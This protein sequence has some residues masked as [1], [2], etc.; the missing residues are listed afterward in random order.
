MSRRAARYP[1]RPR[2]RFIKKLYE[3]HLGKPV[4]TETVPGQPYRYCPTCHRNRS[5]DSFNK[6][7]PRTLCNNCR[8]A[9]FR[10]CKICLSTFWGS[11]NVHVCSDE[12]WEK[13]APGLSVARINKLRKSTWETRPRP[14]KLEGK[15]HSF[16]WYVKLI[17]EYYFIVEIAEL[18]EMFDTDLTALPDTAE[19]LREKAAFKKFTGPRIAAFFDAID[20]GNFVGPAARSVGVSEKTIAAWVQRGVEERKGNYWNFAKTLRMKIASVEVGLVG[21]VY[22]RAMLD[23]KGGGKLALDLVKHRYRSRWGKGKEVAIKNNN[24]NMNIGVQINMQAA[25]QLPITDRRQLLAK[26]QHL[27]GVQPRVVDMPEIDEEKRQREAA[28]WL[29]EIATSPEEDLS[30]IRISL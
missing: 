28:G 22:D 7:D 29:L 10:V 15:R 6:H 25:E 4:I 21:R 1:L 13:Q 24:A 3:T 9:R 12:C 2:N 27:A 8:F 20:K 23:P 16:P 19:S 5:L 18:A 30:H 11:P 14:I 17:S 26:L